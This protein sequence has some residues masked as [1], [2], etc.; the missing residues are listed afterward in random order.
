M[1]FKVFLLMCTLEH[2]SLSFYTTFSTFQS[3]Y[4]SVPPSPCITVYLSFLPN[5]LHSDPCI[6]A[7]IH[8]ICILNDLLRWYSCHSQRHI[9]AILVEIQ[10]KSS[11]WMWY[12]VFSQT[13]VNEFHLNATG[14]NTKRIHRIRICAF[15]SKYQ[16]HEN[17]KSHFNV[18][19]CLLIC[20]LD[21]MY[22]FSLNK[23]NYELTW[24]AKKKTKK[25]KKK[26]KKGGKRLLLSFS[27]FSAV[28]LKNY[29]ISEK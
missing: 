21:D 17:C 16:I 5:L 3:Q 25:N 7:Q 12:F 18:S 14:N 8:S 24:L 6:R 9:L 2:N 27:V 29:I 13:I 10:L 28:L 23:L 4:C 19:N 20:T 15:V 22:C 1:Q 26:K 11:L